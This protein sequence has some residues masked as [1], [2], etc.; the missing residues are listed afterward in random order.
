MKKTFLALAILASSI[1]YAA[2]P[3][4]DEAIEKNFKAMFPKAEKVTWYE[5][6]KHYEVLFENEAVK[7]RMWYNKAGD[8]V[9]TERY[10]KQDG[11]CPFILA[12]V[13][14]KYSDKKIFGV[15][16]VN[17]E[18]GIRYYIILEDEKKW[19]HVNSDG[20]GNLNLTKKY[21]KA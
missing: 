8:V 16:E 17:N 14:S 19:Y 9:K 6:D 15:T 7:C 21:I 12:K 20:A 18:E 2:T 5:N 3:V 13:K 1:L 4:V 10:Y 11:L